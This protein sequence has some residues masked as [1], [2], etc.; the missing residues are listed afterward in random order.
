LVDG[1][2][3]ET[4]GIYMPENVIITYNKKYINWS[5]LFIVQHELLVCQNIIYAESAITSIYVKYIIIF[6]CTLELTWMLIK[7]NDLIIS[8]AL[9]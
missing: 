2:K 1:G 8:F 3:R 7:L 5:L 9:I 4:S 6:Y